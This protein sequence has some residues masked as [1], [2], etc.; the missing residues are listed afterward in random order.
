MLL[1]IIDNAVDG[2]TGGGG[3]DDG[4]GGRPFVGRVAVCPD[5]RPSSRS[6]ATITTGLRVRNNAPRRVAPLASALVVHASSKGRRRGD[7]SDGSDDDGDDDPARDIG[8]FGVGLKQACA[9][10]SDLSFVLATNGS[11]VEV[12]VLAKALQRKEGP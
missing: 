12:G 6:G 11:A 9:A 7:G 3:E 2:A 8:E 1:D 10:L 4:G 5:V